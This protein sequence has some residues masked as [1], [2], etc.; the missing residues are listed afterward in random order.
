MYEN[1]LNLLDDDK[2]TDQYFTEVHLTFVLRQYAQM[3][4]TLDIH[5]WCTDSASPTRYVMY[6]WQWL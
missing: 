1:R 2:N 4:D 5:D 6:T 3:L